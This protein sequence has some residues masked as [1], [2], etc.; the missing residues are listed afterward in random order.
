LL[1]DLD[2]LVEPTAPGDPDSPLL[3]LTEVKEALARRSPISPSA[4]SS[5]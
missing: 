2:A 5:S 3:K 4:R 1:Q